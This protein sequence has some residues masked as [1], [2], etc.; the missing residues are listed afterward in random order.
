MAPLVDNATQ[1]AESLYRGSVEAMSNA[2]TDATTMAEGFG[3]TVAAANATIG[4][5]GAQHAFSWSGYL[6]AIGILLFLLAALWGAVWLLRRYGP[7]RF[8][9]QPGAFPRDALR[10]EAQVPLGQRKGLVVVRFLDRR[11]LLGVTDQR[12]SL[13]TEM[14]ADHERSTDEDFDSLLEKAQHTRPPAP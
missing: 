1:A 6:Q 12:I 4:V 8:L 13:L 10:V 5:E 11:L 14:D 2:T 7:F 3:R 9:P